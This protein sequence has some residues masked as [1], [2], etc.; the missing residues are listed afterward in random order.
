M[1]I[2][3]WCWICAAFLAVQILSLG[4]VPFELTEPFDKVFHILAFG[5]LAM[6][7]WIATDGRR[8]VL[9]IV[10][11]MMLG[12]ADE[13]RQAFIPTRTADLMDFLADALAACAVGAVMYWRGLEA[14]KAGRKAAR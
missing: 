7:L 2:N 10:G 1:R 12:L 3:S 8:P 13:A 4:S 14:A 6:M 11:V 9:V 5:S